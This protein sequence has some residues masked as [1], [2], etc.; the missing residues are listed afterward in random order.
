MRFSQ[1]PGTVELVLRRGLRICVPRP[2]PAGGGFEKRGPIEV[3]SRHTRGDRPGSDAAND[4][5][6]AKAK[7]H[8]ASG[9][10]GSRNAVNRKK[11][12]RRAGPQKLAGSVARKEPEKVH[13]KRRPAECSRP[14]ASPAGWRR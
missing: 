3:N 14:A 6:S 1:R 7:L 10:D 8:V 9:N 2:R 4:G 13:R 5:A 12:S 11:G